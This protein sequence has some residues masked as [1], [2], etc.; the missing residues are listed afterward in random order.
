MET[1]TASARLPAEL[2]GQRLDQAAAAVFPAFSRTRLSAWIR[3]GALTV[4]GGQARPRDIVLGGEELRLE[5]PAAADPMGAAQAVDFIRV[6]EDEHLLVVNKPPGLVVHPGAG[7]GDHTLLNGLLHFDPDLAALPRAGI[8]HRLDKDTSGLLVIARSLEAHTALVRALKRREVKRLY[9]GVAEGVMSGGASVRAPLGRHPRARTRMA[10]RAD[11]RA[12]AT[13]LRVLE[14]F[15]AH[16]LVEATLETGRTHQIRVH[17]NHQGHPL[18]GDRSYGFRGRIPAGAD[19]SLRERL[20]TFPRQ[21][22]HAR[23]LAL[24]HPLTG[25]SMHWT[26][27]LPEDIQGLLAALRSDAE[28]GV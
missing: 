12:A 28:G 7:H 4:D 25:E 26:A 9:W 1:L 16:C 22:L 19:A 15:R 10:V 8:V 20:R 18:V 24:V 3:A 21:A 6:F 2:A 14:R 5:A 11:G 13:H 27:P 17:L 23:E